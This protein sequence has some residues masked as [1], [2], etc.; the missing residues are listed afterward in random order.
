LLL[1]LCP[2]LRVALVSYL[3]D[4]SAKPIIVYKGL[5]VTTPNK[6]KSRPVKTN[7]LRVSDREKMAK[8]ITL[9]ISTVAEDGELRVYYNGLWKDLKAGNL[10]PL[11]LGDLNDRVA[12]TYFQETTSISFANTSGPYTR[13]TSLP[14]LYIN[15]NKPDSRKVLALLDSGLECNIISIRLAKALGLPI[16]EIKV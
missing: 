4:D 15:I 8:Y 11:A 2:P 16:R 6:P 12:K 14:S 9:V 10:T 1:E 3:K 7:V 13:L 5:A